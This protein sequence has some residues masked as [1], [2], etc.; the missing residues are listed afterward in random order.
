MPSTSFNS[1]SM[2]FDSSTVMTPSLPTFSIA[3]ATISPIRLSPDEIVATCAMR[4]RSEI[5]T[6][7]SLIA[8]TTASTAFWMPILSC[9]GLAPAVTLR[10]PSPM[11]AAAST[12]EVVVPSPAMSFVLLATSLTSWAP[13]FSNASS[14]SISFA[15]VTPSFVIVGE[16]NFLSST[17]FR[18][19]GPMVIRTASAT[20]STPRLSAERAS[21][22]YASCFAIDRP[23]SR[24]FLSRQTASVPGGKY[25]H[26][27]TPKRRVLAVSPVER[28]LKWSEPPAGGI[29]VMPMAQPDPT[30][31][32]GRA[33]AWGVAIGVGAV[34]LRE[35]VRPREEQAQLIDWRRVEEMALSRCAEPNEPAPDLSRDRAY[36][37]IQA[38]LE[39]LLVEA[40]GPG[41]AA[42]GTRLYPGLQAV[43][44]RQW[45]RFNVRI[46]R[47][48]FEPL[49]KLQRLIP[50]SLMLIFGQRGISRYLGLI[51]GLL[52]RRV[53]GQYDPALLGREPVET[54]S[55]ILVEPNVQAWAQKDHLP[56]DELRRWLAMHE[57]THAWEFKAHPWLQEYLEGLLNQVL[58]GRLGDGHRP[59]RLELLRTLTIG[60][61]QQWKAIAKVQAVMSLLEGYSNLIMND[62]GRRQLPHFALLEGAYRRRQQERPPLEK[63]FL[64]LTG[65]EMKMRQYVLGERFCQAVRDAGGPA[66]LARVWEGPELLPT[67][68]E[69]QRPQL[70]IDRVRVR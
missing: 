5:W 11:I 65:L 2:P 22:S 28:Q 69:I 58:I 8:L 67:M 7:C 32:V 10:R 33:M 60:V 46:F 45:V 41:S 70:Y 24:L 21:A 35:L 34:V 53:L 36:Q 31:R 1:S 39:P 50:G 9:I 57:M 20:L 42:P 26:F 64:R 54:S 47:Q 16:P 6:D 30:R 59:S 18:P 48:M 40:L 25:P 23:P 38:E 61:G 43:G 51:L 62:V 29:P 37:A 49:E 19:L 27:S 66:L 13:I 4:S 63:L 12:T 3:L 55:L 56:L 44:R 52:A 17:T 68:A 15:I 14:S